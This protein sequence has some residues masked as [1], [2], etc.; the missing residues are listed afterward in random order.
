MNQAVVEDGGDG[1]Y[2]KKKGWRVIAPCPDDQVDESEHFTRKKTS[3]CRRV[4]ARRVT[5]HQN[6]PKRVL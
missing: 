2:S 5:Y 3:T 6:N 1:E 4:F